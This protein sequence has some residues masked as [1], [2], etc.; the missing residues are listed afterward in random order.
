MSSN[1]EHNRFALYSEYHRFV[2]R[3]PYSRTSAG[4]ELKHS[5]ML[6]ITNLPEPV[7]ADDIREIFKSYELLDILAIPLN[8]PGPAKGQAL[9]YFDDEEVAKRARNEVNGRLFRK[10]ILGVDFAIVMNAPNNLIVRID[11]IEKSLGFMDIREMYSHLGRLAAIVPRE[12]D[13]VQNLGFALL[14]LLN[15]EENDACED[16]DL[17]I[18]EFSLSSMF[19]KRPEAPERADPICRGLPEAITREELED[20]YQETGQCWMIHRTPRPSS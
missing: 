11:G 18:R 9:V 17:V 13:G 16:K 20:S 15:S 1:S 4:E 14:C 2:R 12:P 8:V 5:N 7:A 6:S 3:F 10:S 19:T